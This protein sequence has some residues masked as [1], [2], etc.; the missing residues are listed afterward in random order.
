MSTTT[1]DLAADRET[2]TGETYLVTAEG[3][4]IAVLQPIWSDEDGVQV[5]LT[6][7]ADWDALPGA[8]AIALGQALQDAGSVQ[9]PC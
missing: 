8:Q 6:M 9:P 7:T 1:W 4:L 2:A 5:S 3:R